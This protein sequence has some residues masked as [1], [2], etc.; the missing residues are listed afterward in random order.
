MLEAKFEGK[1]HSL[2]SMHFSPKSY[3]V[4]DNVEYG[5]DGQATDNNLIRRMRVTCWLPNATNIHSQYVIPIASPLQ[6]FGRPQLN[7]TSYVH[8]RSYCKLPQSFR[9]LD[10]LCSETEGKL[11][12]M[13]QFRSSCWHWNG[14][15]GSLNTANWFPTALLFDPPCCGETIRPDMQ[16]QLTLFVKLWLKLLKY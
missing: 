12:M 13:T 3:R 15:V 11:L 9:G 4:W 1:K 6:V 5:R 8:C 10:W 14:S 16:F 2:C 7:V